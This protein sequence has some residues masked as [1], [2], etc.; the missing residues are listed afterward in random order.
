MPLDYENDG[1]NVQLQPVLE[2]VVAWHGAVVQGV[3]NPQ[4]G[5]GLPSLEEVRE[6][7]RAALPERDAADLEALSR[8]LE[9]QAQ[10]FSLVQGAAFAEF[11]DSYQAF[12]HALRKKE[13]EGL[14][15]QRLF[16]PESGLKPGEGV[17]RELVR[18]N[19]RLSRKGEPFALICVS[20]PDDLT[21]EEAG[22]YGRY[23]RLCLRGF[24]DAYRL[25]RHEFLI[26]LKQSGISGA[27][28]AVKRLQGMLRPHQLDEKPVYCLAQPFKGDDMAQLLAHMQ[29]DIEAAQY[30]IG[31]VIELK[32]LSPLQRLVGD[33]NG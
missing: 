8:Y 14:R 16:D 15:Y 31:A 28:A 32:E 20:C 17:M 27:R 33:P 30:H 26:V 11:E 25:N 3:M 24:D 4:D 29:A 12:F 18:E 5:G 6:M 21:A 7:I 2:A 13:Q 9:E 1:P 22:L 10:K 23:I 19:E